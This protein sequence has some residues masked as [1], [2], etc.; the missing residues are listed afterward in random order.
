M[1]GLNLIKI[2]PVSVRAGFRS[3]LVLIHVSLCDITLY[4]RIPK[5]YL[6][7]FL[8]LHRACWRVTQLLH[9]PLHIYKIYTLKH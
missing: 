8:L 9:L 1:R 5:A 7:F 3:Q 2:S 4:F 6:V